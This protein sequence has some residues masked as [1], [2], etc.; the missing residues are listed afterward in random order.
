MAHLLKRK[1]KERD[2]IDRREPFCPSTAN[3][4]LA[5]CAGGVFIDRRREA[6]PECG[7][8]PDEHAHAEISHLREGESE[9]GELTDDIALVPRDDMPEIVRVAKIIAD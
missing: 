7:R 9:E 2:P 4:S 5:D 6:R 1:L 8:E 3:I